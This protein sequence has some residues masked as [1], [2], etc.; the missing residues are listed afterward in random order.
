M[1]NSPRK[2]AFDILQD[3]HI[4][5]S[6]ANLSLKD[7]LKNQKPLDAS[8]ITRIVFGVLQNEIYIDYYIKKYTKGK[9][10]KPKI[11]E[12]LRIGVYQILFMD[13]V[14]DNAAVDECVKITKQLK[15]QSLSG[16]V[17]GVLRSISREKDNLPQISA[18][19]KAEYLS[20][21]YSHPLWLVE[22]FMSEFSKED[23]EQILIANNQNAPIVCRVNTVKTTVN[24]VIKKLENIEVTVCETPENSLIL[25]KTGDIEQLQAFQDGDIYVQD[26]ASQY[27]VSVLSPTEGST[28]IDCCSAP[29]GKSFLSAQYMQNK[30]EIFSF[31]IHPHKLEIIEK[32][33]SR[34]GLDIIKT[35]VQDASVF[36]V[37]LEKTADFVLCDAPCSGLGIIRR[38]PEIRYK[39]DISELPQIQLDILSNVSR[40]VKNGGTLVYST[41][42]IISDE[43]TQVVEKFLENNEDFYLEDFT[44][45]GKSQS[46]LTLLPH[47][48][49]TDGFFIAKLRRK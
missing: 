33:A 12:I 20:V 8:F 47:I 15:L 44:I 49:N 16:F 7:R 41:C 31:D 9:R 43:N 34:L 30:G 40:Y 22:K 1:T 24:D 27:A 3:V 42:T 28:L 10:I 39:E 19:T 14:P 32:T 29:G 2:I 48:H 11:M 23:V 37:K 38:K 6:Y 13:K 21:K 45:Q 35:G 46:M 4:N 36:D 17:N 18:S 25:S 26:F 5:K